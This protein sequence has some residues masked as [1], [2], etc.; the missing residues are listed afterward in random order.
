MVTDDK[1]ASFGE[2]ERDRADDIPGDA[3]A[4]TMLRSIAIVTTIAGF[5]PFIDRILT[6]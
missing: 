1:G 2:D 5:R 4:L 6:D 3:K